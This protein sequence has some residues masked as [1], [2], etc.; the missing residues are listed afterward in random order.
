MTFVLFL[1]PCPRCHHT[2]STT[3]T[4]GQEVGGVRAQVAADGW[5]LQ[6]A[7]VPDVL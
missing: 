3:S 7:Q 5:L 2:A 6:A 4:V 1:I